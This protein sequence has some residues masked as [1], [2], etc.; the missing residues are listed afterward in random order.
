MMKFTFPGPG[1]SYSLHNHSTFS[2]GASTLEEMCIAGK[3]SNLRVLGISDHWC[4]PICEGTDWAEWCMKHENLDEY[5]ETLLKLKSKYEDENFSL[6]IGLEVE[7]YP[8]N[9]DSVLKNLQK[10]PID[11]LIGSVHFTGTFSVDH[12]IADWD[13]LSQEEMDDICEKYWQQLERAAGCEAFSFIGHLD[14]P[15][16]Y[17]LI[18]NTKYYPHAEKVL[19]VLQR[20]N[21]AME[22]NTAGWFKNCA[23]QYPAASIIQSALKRKIPMVISADAHHHSHITRNFDKASALIT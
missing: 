21:G 4:V 11:Y 7:F 19:D 8:E 5:V 14:L 6:K 13:G 20:N 3:S 10:Y 17:N 2:D 22:I 18:D 16:K 12:D 9:I 23:E 1:S 15:K